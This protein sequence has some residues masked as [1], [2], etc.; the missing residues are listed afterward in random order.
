[1]RRISEAI[2]ETTPHMTRS[3]RLLAGY[4]IDH[5]D[6]AA[7]MNSFELASVTGLS[8]S[9]VVRF[10]GGL[11][12]G[13]YAELQEALREE[14]KY[15][16][17]VLER[18]DVIREVASDGDL[19]AGIA[20]TDALNIK[21]TMSGNSPEALTSLATRLLMSARV[22][23]YGQGFAAPAALYL[24]SYLGLLLPG[25]ICVNLSG[26]DALSTLGG[27][28]DG[29]ALIVISFPLHTPATLELLSYANCR[30]ALVVTISE[31][32]DSKA[33][34]C[35]DISLMSEWGDLGVN[36]SLAPVIS[37]CSALV[38]LLARRDDQAER[39]LR[40]VHDATTFKMGGKP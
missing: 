29:D 7:F 22:Y 40:A 37:L 35:A 6:R 36:G 23:V 25:V 21:K 8:Q 3:Q 19:M 11:G 16:L 32:E 14:L 15:R 20:M 13:G 34:V 28:T 30:E 12:Y 10:A 38:C 26:M 24:A 33:G 1:M 18:F 39:K 17:D 5:C 2:A 4:I 31:G 9:T 27:L